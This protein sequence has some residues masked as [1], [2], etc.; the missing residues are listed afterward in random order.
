MDWLKKILENAVYV[1]DG[2][3][4]VEETMKK[5]KEEF[6]KNAVPKADF[7]AKVKELETANTTITNLKEDNAGNEELQKTIKA[8]ESTISTMKKEHEEEIKGMKIDSAISKL[9]TDN[10][11]KHPELLSGKFDRS[12]V[13]VGK[14]GTVSG[15]T[16]QLGGIKESY[17][18]LF[19]SKPPIS[20]RNPLNPDASGTNVTFENLVNSADN[21]T[22]EEVAAQFAAMEKQ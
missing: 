2:K 18:D 12:K 16:E 14:D 20:G 19:G 5:V 11:V 9:L 13:V 22:A 8:H 7:N 6:P 1:E 21:M 10:H 15:L 17:K 3:L 4:N